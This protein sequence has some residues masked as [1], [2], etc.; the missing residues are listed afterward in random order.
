MKK[1]IA[2]SRKLAFVLALAL[3]VTAANPTLAYASA[4]LIDNGGAEE[5][6]GTWSWNNFATITVT[7][8]ESASGN[9][10]LLATNR[11]STGAG[12]SQSITGEIEP[13]V[14][15][16]VSAKVKYTTGPDVRD[17]NVSVQN[18]PDWTYISIM[19]T[20][21]ITKG[22]WGLVEGEFTCPE[23]GE[24]FD[25]SNSFVFVETSWTPEQDPENDLMD[26]YVDDISVIPVGSDDGATDS[27]AEP[28][29]D[30]NTDVNTD[31]TTVANTDAPKTGVSSMAFIYVSALAF[32]LF[33]LV[34][35]NI[36]KKRELSFK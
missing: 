15:Y 23:P 1:I 25:A 4:E 32:T 20:G 34:T 2:L 33:G 5:G 17:F 16:K 28:D 7:D 24:K 31:S 29:T 30:A 11:D 21:T 19:A 22:E 14:T 12:P 18:G 26:F 3:V 9:Y 35:L 27:N 10:S 36:L 8:A 6:L 13:G